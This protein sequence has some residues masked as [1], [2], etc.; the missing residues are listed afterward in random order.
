MSELNTAKT[1][2]D[3]DTEEA[4]PSTP[5]KPRRGGGWL[6]LLA[7]LL[8]MAALALGWAGREALHALQDEL[9][10]LR[11]QTPPGVASLETRLTALE[12]WP[13][14]L[15]DEI[16]RLQQQLAS[17]PPVST[18]VPALQQALAQLSQRLD[19]VEQSLEA[20]TTSPAT[21]RR[22]QLLHESLWLLRTANRHWQ[23]NRDRDAALR[24]MELAEHNLHQ[25]DLPW[26]EPIRAELARERAELRAL[27]AIDLEGLTHEL[28]ALAEQAR[29]LPSP[30][31]GPLRYGR[32]GPTDTTSAQAQHDE[33]SL[34]ARIWSELSGLVVV[35]SRTV[36][37]APLLPPAQSA[38]LRERL[39]LR[40]EQARVAALRGQPSL[41]REAL[42]SAA[43]WSQQGFDSAAPET[44][45]LVEQLERLQSRPVVHAPLDLSGSL[46]LLRQHLDGQ[47]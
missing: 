22:E 24:A 18:E 34:S 38:Y 8:A 13:P 29:R 46:T 10:Q 45:A 4:P 12:P 21:Q 15:E 11:L 37:D 44:V 6:T 33:A 3:Q 5:V 2:S 32:E 35:R 7:L 30:Q 42:Q 17:L 14:Q 23:L 16:E 36:D 9:D 43:T 40:L 31:P 19:R 20:L 26:L 47:P 25:L 41:Y 27:P 28:A 39:V 1:L